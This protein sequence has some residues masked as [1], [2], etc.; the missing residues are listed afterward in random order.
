MLNIA[1]GEVLGRLIGKGMVLV[2]S[3]L[4]AGI[5]GAVRTWMESIIG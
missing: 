3:G 5:E 1:V 4:R 2:C